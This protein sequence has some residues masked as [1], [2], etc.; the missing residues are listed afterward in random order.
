MHEQTQIWSLYRIT[1][2]NNGKNYIGQAADLSKR[3]SDHRRAVRLN[4][5]TQAIHHAIIKY[6]IDNFEF[7]VIA[8]CKTQDDANFIETELVSQYDSFIAND[9]GYNVTLGGMNAPKTEEW[10]KVISQKARER[11]PITSEQMKEIAA[12]RPDS[13]YDHSRGNQ[14]ALGNTH[15]DE[16]KAMISAREHTEEEKKQRAA[17]LK[18]AYDEGR[19]TSYFRE[20]EPWN[21]GTTGVMKPNSTSFKPGQEPH[22]KTKFTEDQIV[23]ILADTRSCKAI[24]KDYGVSLGTIWNLKKKYKQNP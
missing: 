20:N 3:W 21:K 4:K 5:P 6:G 11:A 10:K 1:N 19:R 2:K 22:N 15:T 7:E 16:W 13:H 24:S 12:Q 18:K 23:A 9:K 8:S 17:S 14:Y